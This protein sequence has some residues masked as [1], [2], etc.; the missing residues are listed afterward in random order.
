MFRG[1]GGRAERKTQKRSFGRQVSLET[2][3][4]MLGEANGRKVGN[5]GGRESHR[6]LSRNGKS[7]GRGFQGGSGGGGRRGDFSMFRTKSTLSKQMSML[8]VRTNSDLD[9]QNLDGP[10]GDRQ[11][12]A[13]NRSVP[14]G[15]YFAALR[16]P[17]LDQVRVSYI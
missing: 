12:D 8:P 10:T 9:L 13:V 2:G 5:G 3:F 7:L 17:E 4:A 11:G 14:A 16:G 15:R 1:G 6:A